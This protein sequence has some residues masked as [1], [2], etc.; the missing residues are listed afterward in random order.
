M[1]VT[2]DFETN[3]DVSIEDPPAQDVQVNQ[4]ITIH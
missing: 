3:N 1:N 2:K 4:V